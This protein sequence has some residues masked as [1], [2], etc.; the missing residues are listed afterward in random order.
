M[1]IDALVQLLSS[2]NPLANVMVCFGA[3]FLVLLV[4]WGNAAISIELTALTTSTANVQCLFIS[5]EIFS[6]VGL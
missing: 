2:C 6:F 5:N 1:H 3:F 4:K